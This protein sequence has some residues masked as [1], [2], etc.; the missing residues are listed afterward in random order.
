MKSQKLSDTMKDSCFLKP[1]GSFRNISEK[2][3][4]DLKIKQKSMQHSWLA[5]QGSSNKQQSNANNNLRNVTYRVVFH[6]RLN[7]NIKVL[8]KYEP[9]VEMLSTLLSVANI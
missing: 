9:H 1:K 6:E 5:T 4:S 7:V 3:Y 2:D 8:S